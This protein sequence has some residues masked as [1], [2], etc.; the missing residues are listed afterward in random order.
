MPSIFEYS[1]NDLKIYFKKLG[2]REFHA[3]QIIDWIYKKG[4]CSWDEMSNLSKSLKAT[5]S[6]KLKMGSLELVKM[7]ES[8]DLETFKF[9][10]RLSTGDLIES[11]LI[12]AHD[13]RTVCVST[14]VGCPAKCAF[15]ASGKQGFFRNLSSPEIVEQVVQINAWLI[16]KGGAGFTCCIHGN[17]RA[18]EKL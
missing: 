5:L 3:G 10:W 4:I 1:L 18:F 12:C 13:R 6:A 7:T 9:L 16:K 11:V 2:E 14:Q 17:G 8:N 15:C